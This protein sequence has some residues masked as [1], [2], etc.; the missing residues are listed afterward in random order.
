MDE[1]MAYILVI[2]IIVLVVGLFVAIRVTATKN[3]VMGKICRWYWNT[4]FKIASHI[5]F[6]G[7]MANFMV[8]VTEDERRQKVIHIDIG[9]ETDHMASRE[10]DRRVAADQARKRR[11]E[12][13]RSECAARGVSVN[14]V[15]DDGSVAWGTDRRGNQCRVDINWN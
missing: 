15:S 11:E 6:C 4:S 1:N 8:A 14:S 3:T 7:W 13:I 9:R 2:C 5:P 12:Q 10:L